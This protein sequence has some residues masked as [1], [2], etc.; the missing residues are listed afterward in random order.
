MFDGMNQFATY[1]FTVVKTFADGVFNGSSQFSR[2]SIFKYITLLRISAS[3][4][5]S[6][7]VVHTQRKHFNIRLIQP[8]PP[9]GFHIHPFPAFDVEQYNI[10]YFTGTDDLNKFLTGISFK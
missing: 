5:R 7:I 3:D 4:D 2:F 9:G 8:Y 6:F 10:R 1:E